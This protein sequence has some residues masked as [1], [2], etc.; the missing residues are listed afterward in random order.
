M[1]SSLPTPVLITNPDGIDRLVEKITGL[2]AVAVDT[3]SNSLYAYRERV[4]LIQFSTPKID[5]LV[6]PL[7]LEDLSPL[8]RIFRNPKVEKIFHA[9]EYDLICM[10]RDYNFEFA[11]LF[12]T[13]VAAR[14]LGREEVGLGS[15]LESEFG[16]KLDKRYQ[17]ANWGQRP[18][19]DYLLAYA[20]LDTHYLISLRDRLHDELVAKNLW[21]LALEDFNRMCQVNGRNNENKSEDCFRVNGAHDLPPQKATVLLELCRYRDYV[22]RKVD[23]PLFKVISDRILLTVASHC[24]HNLNELAEL[25]GLTQ[26]TLQRHGKGLLA[27]V[28]RGLK[29]QPVYPTRSSR[30]ND[31]YLSRL[32]SLRSWRKNTAVKMGVKSDVVL[33]RDLMFVLAEQN[34]CC[35]KNL[36]AV[37]ESVPWRLEHFGDQILAVLQS[38]AQAQTAHLIR[39]NT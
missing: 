4:C 15:M 35:Q 39:N 37:L 36:A 16:V 9:A 10:K 38:K 7:A 19:P 27:A 2:P 23:R 6:D 18:L 30:P 28:E 1:T 21:P 32:E 14:I 12:D 29:E 25:H 3:E 33:P 34:P 31:Q 26:P 13:M 24:P 8:D 11:N 17:R 5:Y 20:R 22:A